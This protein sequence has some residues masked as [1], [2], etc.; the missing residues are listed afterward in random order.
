MLGDVHGEAADRRVPKEA[1]TERLVKALRSTGRGQR[2]AGQNLLAEA[3]SGP[4]ILTSGGNGRGYSSP[5]T[6]SVMI[7]AF[8]MS[9]CWLRYISSESSQRIYNRANFS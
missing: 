3:G 5:K 9:S 7:R 6:V 2:S 8:L 1:A 4:T